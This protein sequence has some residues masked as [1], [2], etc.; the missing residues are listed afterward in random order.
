MQCGGHGRSGRLDFDRRV[1]AFG[2]ACEGGWG[3]IKNSSRAATR[4]CFFMFS[5]YE[6]ELGLGLIGDAFSVIQR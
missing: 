2:F 6:N 1:R 3:A 5:I 4:H